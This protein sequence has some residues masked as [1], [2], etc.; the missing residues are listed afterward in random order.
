MTLD[1]IAKLLLIIGGLFILS[2]V[3]WQLGWIQAL[4]LGRLPGDIAIEK[5]NVRI[6]FPIATSILISI[7]LMVLA[8][9]FRR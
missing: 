9:L 6:Y 4:K 8:W 5:E 1:P 3:A 7:V 2:G